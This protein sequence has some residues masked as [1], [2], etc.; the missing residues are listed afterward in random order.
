MQRLPAKYIIVCI[1]LYKCFFCLHV[2][3]VATTY[4]ISIVSHQSFLNLCS[5]SLPWFYL[6]TKSQIDFSAVFSRKNN[7]L[8]RE[9]ILSSLPKVFFEKLVLKNLQNLENTC[10]GRLYSRV[11]RNFQEHLL[12]EIT[13]I[14]TEKNL[15]VTDFCSFIWLYQNYK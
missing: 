12:W 8:C 1:K 15:L 11:L 10:A 2:Q 6:T 7:E 4:F 14:I 13:N 5:K 9:C 3:H